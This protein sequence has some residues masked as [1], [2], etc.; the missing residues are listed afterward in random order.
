M[1]TTQAALYLHL[2]S[3]VSL[4]AANAALAAEQAPIPSDAFL[5]FFAAINSGTK[6]AVDGLN[7]KIQLNG[8]A[9]ENNAVNISGISGLSP[10]LSPGNS[11]RQSSTYW[12]G[13]GGG[14]GTLTVPLGHAF[15][16]QVDLGS[17]AIGNRP[18]GE[19][20]THLFWRDPD[21]GMIGVLGSGMLLG[22]KVGRGV[23]TAAGEFEAFLDRFTARTVIGM[24]GSSAYTA[25]L[26]RR[27]I[28]A[29]G[30][31]QAFIT[32]D[33]FHDLTE[34]TFYPID[35]L[36]L[37]AGHIYSFGRNA[38][39]GEVEYM[40]PQFRGGNIAPSV[41]V[42]G[43]YGWNASSNIMAGLRVYFGNHDKSLIRRHREDDP[44][45]KQSY[46]TPT[47]TPMSGGNEGC[48]YGTNPASIARNTGSG[49]CRDKTTCTRNCPAPTAGNCL[50]PG[51]IFPAP[52]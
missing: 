52:C 51:G 42:S 2:F 27:Q 3:G 19:A 26:S 10:R 35:D 43:A 47:I 20:S 37:S 29:Y 38:V 34:V 6:P 18:R 39:T 9:S 24:Q 33:Y 36:A 32:P 31:R 7:G 22:S 49:L 30:G 25:N 50:S 15:G 1:K 8:G 45:I 28:K 41:F 12:N 14:I 48:E 11:T 4:L 17:G 13:I 5:P 21:K 46:L 23:W 40:L 44:K 16:A